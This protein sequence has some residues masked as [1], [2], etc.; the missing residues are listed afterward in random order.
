[1]ISFEAEFHTQPNPALQPTASRARSSGFRSGVGV[2]ALH[3]SL[4]PPPDSATIASGVAPHSYKETP[5]G[6][7]SHDPH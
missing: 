1:M 6:Q 4:T 3:F 5:H 7:L 2:A